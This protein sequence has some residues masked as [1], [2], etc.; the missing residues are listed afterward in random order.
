LQIRIVFD[1]D[2]FVVGVEIYNVEVADLGDGKFVD[3]LAALVVEVLVCLDGR[4]SLEGG[5]VV[6]VE[7]QLDV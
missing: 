3:E 2:A 5:F 1:L 7:G 4:D 6:D